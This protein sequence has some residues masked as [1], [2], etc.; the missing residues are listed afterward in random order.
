MKNIITLLFVFFTIPAIGYQLRSQ[1]ATTQNDE[2]EKRLIMTCQPEETICQQTC[3]I[4]K[5]CILPETICQDCATRQSQLFTTLFTDIKSIFKTDPMFIEPAQVAQFFRTKKFMVITYDAFLNFI[6]PEKKLKIKADYESLCYV[7]VDSA[8]MLVTIDEQTSQ[9]SDLVGT[10]CHDR[11]GFSALLP[12]ELNT[13][14]S[15]KTLDFWK[16]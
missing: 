2:L 6:T 15:N 13:N 1:I 16:N 12:M 7:D 10:I 9:M 3:G 8:M 5:G 14:F 11:Q 4:Q